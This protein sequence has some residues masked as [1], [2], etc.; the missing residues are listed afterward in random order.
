MKIEKF[1]EEVNRSPVGI[2]HLKIKVTP[3]LLKEWN[4][5]KEDYQI[6][7]LAPLYALKEQQKEQQQR[8]KIE[9]KIMEANKLTSKETEVF[10]EVTKILSAERS[11]KYRGRILI[12]K[13][14]SGFSLITTLKFIP[15][16]NQVVSEI[17]EKYKIKPKQL[18]KELQKVFPKN[19]ELVNEIVE[20]KYSYLLDRILHKLQYKEEFNRLEWIFLLLHLEEDWLTGI[21]KWLKARREI[22]DWENKKFPNLNKEINVSRHTTLK[23]PREYFRSL[24][25]YILYDAKGEILHKDWQTWSR[26]EIEIETIDSPEKEVVCIKN[27]EPYIR[28]KIYG[29]TNISKMRALSKAI[30]R[31]QKELPVYKARALIQS[32]PEKNLKKAIYYYL[33]KGMRLPPK[34]AN[35]LLL[36]LN[37]KKGISIRADSREIKRFEEFFGI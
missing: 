36:K 22:E 20:N 15:T 9:R 37:Y 35:I 11:L 1:C 29:D 8:K 28:V 17:R 2:K 14:P 19:K 16:F 3:E 7:D 4:F 34:R 30:K 13:T 5:I 24:K 12:N 27:F 6:N 32:N 31:R 26:N 25:N 10:Q 18:L 21:G 23:L 33:R